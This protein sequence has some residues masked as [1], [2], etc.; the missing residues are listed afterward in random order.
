MLELACP[1]VVDEAPLQRAPPSSAGAAKRLMYTAK[2]A[3]GGQ[4]VDGL[5]VV[6]S[7]VTVPMLL[8]AERNSS[9]VMLS[10]VREFSFCQV[11]CTGQQRKTPKPARDQDHPHRVYNR[12]RKQTFEKAKL[13][14][15]G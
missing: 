1:D 7:R 10:S 14:L 4:N 2:S 8:P 15:P 6:K 5:V 11:A 12:T 3:A 9:L 13:N